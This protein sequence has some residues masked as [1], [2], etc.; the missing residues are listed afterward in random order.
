MRKVD[1]EP[2]QFFRAAA[3]LY[4][5]N[6]EWYFQT[7]EEDRGPYTK[8]EV[9]EAALEAYCCEMADLAGIGPTNSIDYDF[10]S[11]DATDSEFSAA[12]KDEIARNKNC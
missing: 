1:K 9:A 3:R 10:M 6:G 7:R 4:C 5:L 8:R 11:E 12:F 2:K